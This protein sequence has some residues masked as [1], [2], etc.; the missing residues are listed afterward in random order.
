M[1]F[2]SQM[3]VGHKSINARRSISVVTLN[4][5]VKESFFEMIIFERLERK[6]GVEHMAIW[7]K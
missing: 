4:L 1:L 3:V 6:L 2:Y 5:K 7:A